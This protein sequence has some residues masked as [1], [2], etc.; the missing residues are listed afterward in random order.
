MRL[1]SS[2]NSYT[3]MQI[4]QLKCSNE[5]SFLTYQ[6]IGTQSGRCNSWEQDM[7]PNYFPFLESILFFWQLNS[8]NNVWSYFYCNCTSPPLQ[9]SAILVKY[10]NEIP[11]F[12]MLL[13]AKLSG[14]F[15]L[16]TIRYH[17]HLQVLWKAICF[18]TIETYFFKDIQLN[19]LGDNQ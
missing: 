11:T 7:C 3:L 14:A 12:L 5:S 6:T 4:L 1:L 13:N 16:S 15:C 2:C 9:G 17:N 19:I 10:N 18:K 8:E